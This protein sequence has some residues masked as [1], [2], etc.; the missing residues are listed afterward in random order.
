MRLLG[1]SKTRRKYVPSGRQG[2]SVDFTAALKRILPNTAAWATDARDGCDPAPV[3]HSEQWVVFRHVSSR[4]YAC[5]HA[6][7][8]M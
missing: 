4:L 6:H 1:R 8:S 5:S 2:T 3:A 7:P